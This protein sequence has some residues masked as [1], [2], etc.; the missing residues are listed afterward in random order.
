MKSHISKNTF[1]VRAGL[2][3]DEQFG[4][5]IPPIYLTSTF[6][7]KQFGVEQQYDYTRT[8]NPTRDALAEAISAL[9]GGYGATVTSSGMSAITLVTSWLNP[10]DYVL[11]P[12]DCYGGT[13]RLFSRLAQRGLLRVKY[14]DQSDLNLLQQTVNQYKPKIVLVETPSNPLLHVVDIHAISK[15]INQSNTLLIVDNTFLT[16]IFQTPINLGADLVIHSSTKYINGHSDVVGGIVVAKNETLHQTMQEWANILGLS[17]APFDSYLTLRGLRTLQLRM[18]AHEKNALALAQVLSEHSSVEEV[19]YPGLTSHPSY[20]IAK[21][22]QSGFGGI[23][24]FEIKNGLQQVRKFFKNLENFSLAESLGGF[25]SLVCH[26]YTMTHA[27]LSSEEK[28][29][30]GISKTL[31][32]ISVG[33]EQQEDITRNILQALEITD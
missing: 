33:I 15:I 28:D 11:I 3:S 14:V 32:R 29:K 7:F 13:F 18:Q 23:L 22:Q 17:G 12:H 8:A 31:I 20:A 19:Y 24:S 5:V 25:E 9:E 6:A 21:K 26:P 27:A 30:A 2:E 10:N 16:P 4:A 1:T